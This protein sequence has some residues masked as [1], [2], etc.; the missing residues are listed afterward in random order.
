MSRSMSAGPV[1]VMFA[2]TL[3]LLLAG[4]HVAHA[5]FVAGASSLA[6]PT[7]R[8][9]ARVVRYQV[10]TNVPGRYYAPRFDGSDAPGPLIITPG[11]IVERY[12][13]AVDDVDRSAAGSSATRHSETRLS[14]VADRKMEYWVLQSAP[15]RHALT[16]Y[17]PPLNN[18]ANSGTETFADNPAEDAAEDAPPAPPAELFEPTAPATVAPDIDQ[19][20]SQSYD[21]A[22]HFLDTCYA[23]PRRFGPY[24]NVGNF[25][26]CLGYHG[27]GNQ[28]SADFGAAGFLYGTP[29]NTWWDFYGYPYLGARLSWAWPFWRFGYF[30]WG[31]PGWGWGGLGYG[32]F[33]YAGYGYPGYGYFGARGLGWWG[34]NPGYL[35]G[36]GGRFGYRGNYHW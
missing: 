14:G 27:V 23:S 1:A 4:G 16:A 26:E 36:W 35:R 11:Q 22:A 2:L 31:W 25:D 8:S 18:D 21:D 3:S 9:G 34:Y 12:R 13:K 20:Y 17:Q 33:G 32:G 10:P 6:L 30:G 28:H 7:E 29:G 15:A 19:F 5:Q 24:P